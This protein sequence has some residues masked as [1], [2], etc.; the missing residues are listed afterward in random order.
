MARPGVTYSEV[1]LIAEQLTTQEKNPTIE[2]IRRL[3]GRGSNSTL[4]AHLRDW[5]QNQTDIK[6]IATK[7][8]LPEEF[9]A[10][11]KGLWEKVMD[12]AENKI[13]IIQTE[14]QDKWMQQHQEIEILTKKNADEQQR[15]QA[16]KQAH[17]ELF[18]EK[19]FLI[20]SLEEIKIKNATLQEQ[21]IGHEKYQQEKQ[22]HVIDLQQQNQQIQANLEHYR[23]A[24]LEQR[25]ADQERYEQQHKQLEQMI[26]QKNQIL[27]V[28]KQEKQLF[29]QKNHQLELEQKYLNEQLTQSRVQQERLD[30]RLTETLENLAKRT[31]AAEHLQNQLNNLNEK[32]S[33]NKVN[34]QQLNIQYNIV[35]QQLNVTQIELKETVEQNKKLIQEKWILGQEKAQLFGQLKQITF[36]K[37][38]EII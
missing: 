34:V 11:L 29:E 14:I 25:M 37:K 23:V 18:Q 35:L 5:K 10:T 15:Y 16:I 13:Q 38:E 30:E 2:M 17:D 21:L 33:Q 22:Q 9:I 36:V 1:A 12:Q 3:L 31:Q 20:H 27:H 7:S 28:T 26:Q 19:Q 24:S 4:S 8:C 6:K 32:F